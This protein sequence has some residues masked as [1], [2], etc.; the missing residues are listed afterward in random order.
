MLQ[1]KTLLS[2]KESKPGDR[3]HLAVAEAVSF[4]GTVVIPVG[5]AVMGAVSQSQRNGHVGRKGKLAVRLISV[6]APDGP[7]RLADIFMAR[8]VAIRRSRSARCCSYRRAA[9]S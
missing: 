4:R 1:T 5:V 6:E 9:A 7:V 2:T 8:A 3:V